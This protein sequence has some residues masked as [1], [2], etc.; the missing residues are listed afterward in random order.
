AQLVAGGQRLVD[1][2]RGRQRGNVEIA[3]PALDVALHLVES[4]RQLVDGDH[5]LADQ[6]V[7]HLATRSAGAPAERALVDGNA[8]PAE[9]GE[10][11]APQGD[12]DLLLPGRE[13][14]RLAAGEEEGADD[15]PVLVGEPATGGDEAAEELLIG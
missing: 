9:R 13:V 6:D 3:E 14:R 11:V 4:A 10:P 5:P 8:P 15:Q 2:R 7:P 1:Q 12:V